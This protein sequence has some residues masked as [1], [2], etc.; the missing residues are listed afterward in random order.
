MK[1]LSHSESRPHAKAHA[2]YYSASIHPLL[3]GKSHDKLT[4]IRK[5]RGAIPLSQLPSETAE[6][7]RPVSEI[8][9]LTGHFIFF[10]FGEIL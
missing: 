7:K 3:L 4:D 8:K 10:L 5:A 9:H 1:A 2:I 6:V